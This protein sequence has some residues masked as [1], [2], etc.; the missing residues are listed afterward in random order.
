MLKAS[1]GKEAAFG[2]TVL[3]LKVA[4]QVEMKMTIFHELKSPAD[5]YPA[6]HDYVEI[7]ENYTSFRLEGRRPSRAALIN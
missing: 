3:G 2:C 4:G 6:V 7:F 1:L 5:V